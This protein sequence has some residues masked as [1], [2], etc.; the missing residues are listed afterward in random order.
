VIF[1]IT[2]S[3]YNKA[4]AHSTRNPQPKSRIEKTDRGFFFRDRRQRAVAARQAMASFEGKRLEITVKHLGQSIVHE[5]RVVMAKQGFAPLLNPHFRFLRA[6]N[7]EAVNFVDRF[8]E[9]AGGF[10]NRPVIH[11][12]DER[13]AKLVEVE[14][15]EVFVLVANLQ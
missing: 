10:E 9:N 8:V 11:A 14:F 6:V 2:I 4:E 1:F 7:H 12:D 3:S 15:D 13:A 5:N